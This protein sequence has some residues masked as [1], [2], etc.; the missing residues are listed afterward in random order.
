MRHC[1]KT[2]TIEDVTIVKGA[3]VLIP[4]YTLHHSSEYWKE[5]EQFIPERFDY[6]FLLSFSE[7]LLIFSFHPDEKA[8]RHPLVYIPFG[9]GPRN[10]I[11]SRFALMEAKMALVTVLRKF[12]F[13][14]SPDTEVC[15]CHST[16]IPNNI[17]PY[18]FH[19]RPGFLLLLVQSMESTLK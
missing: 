15:T 16:R 5:P 3:R 7:L 13:E 4:I 6:S 11:G 9:F 8:K 10:C 12:K 14:R 2:C 18:R 17:V 1:E 19:S